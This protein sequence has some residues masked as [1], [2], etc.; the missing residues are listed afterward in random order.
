RRCSLRGRWIV[1]VHILGSG[2]IGASLGLA[3]S[4]KRPHVSLEDTSPTA[5]QLAAD[6]GAGRVK[7]ARDAEVDEPT[8]DTFRPDIV[9]VAT[10]PDVAARVIATALETYPDATVTDVASVKTRLLES[11]KELVTESQLDRYIGC[12]PMA[13]R[14]RSGAIAAQSDLFTARPWVI[15]SDENT[16][17]DRLGEVIAMAE[18]T[19]ASVIHLDP[20]IHDA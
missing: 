5:Q 13:G 10:P 14:E 15:C 20:H 8:E 19:G 9:V 18:D 11:V 16:P 6:L 4:D 17:A 3:L 7:P 1:R 2:L 12:H